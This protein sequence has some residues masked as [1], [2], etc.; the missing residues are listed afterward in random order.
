MTQKGWFLFLAMALFWGI[1]YFFIKL[2]VRELDPL[3]VVFARV[4]IATAVL[5]PVAAH[6]HILRAVGKRWYLLPLLSLIQIVGPFLF[7]SY[8]EQHLAS[9]LT[10]LLIAAEP[11][12]VVLLALRFER[13]ERVSWLRLVGLLTGMGGVVLLVGLD[14]GGDG[15]SLLGAGLVLLATTGYAAGALL[16]KQPV[17]TSLPR[18]SVVTS[19]CTLAT[20]VL[21]PFA[22]IRW[23]GRLPSLEVIA[24]LLVLGLV[25]T[26]L[27]WLTFFAL[28]AEVGASRGTVFT[29]A[30]PAV[31]VLLG[32]AF[33]HEA[34]TVAT[35]AGF[36]LILIGSWLSTTGT[37]P[38]GKRFL[39]SDRR[40]PQAG[41][42][43]LR[44]ERS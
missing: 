41:A 13:S 14:M 34:L 2:A 15:Q 8:G 16:V 3:V 25:C 30:N 9:S 31:S 44:Q 17:I 37:V 33:L 23:P 38:L 35:I 11:L 40:A 19:E 22:I 29:Y 43:T 42:D 5:L 10:S 4:A 6:Q 20:L 1:P 18:L 27:A 36:L 28:V 39:R 26:A 24:S 32:V 7:V 21:A 12:L